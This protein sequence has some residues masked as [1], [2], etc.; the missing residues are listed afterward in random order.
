MTTDTFA[1]LNGAVSHVVVLDQIILQ[2]VYMHLS[3][4]NIAGFFL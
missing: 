4:L 3:K 1:D 2:Q